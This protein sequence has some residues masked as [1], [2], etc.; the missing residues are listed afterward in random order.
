MIQMQEFQANKIH[1]VKANN[2]I[3]NIKIWK[4]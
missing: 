1:I 3:Q 2:H 4:R